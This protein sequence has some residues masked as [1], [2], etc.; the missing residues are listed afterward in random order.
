MEQQ[1]RKRRQMLNKEFK[2]FSE[3]IAE[4]AVNSVR[5]SRHLLPFLLTEPTRLVTH[6]SLIFRSANYH[7]KAF[8]SERTFASNQRPIVWFICLIR[9]FWWSH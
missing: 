2:S 8:P 3:R 9:H 7:L 4:A 1:E 6:W 5:V